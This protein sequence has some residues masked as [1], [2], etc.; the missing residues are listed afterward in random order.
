M[1]HDSTMPDPP[2]APPGRGAST[3]TPNRFEAQRIELEPDALVD[4]DGEPL[5]L[6]TQLFRDDTRSILTWNDSPDIPFRVGCSPYRG[7]EHGCAYCYA[8]PSHEYLGFSAGLEFESKIV[9]KERAADLLR[10]ELAKKSWEPQ[11]V[12]MSGITDVYQPVERRLGL[13]RRCLEVFAEFRNPVAI[14]TKNHLVTRDADLLG[15]LARFR[16][17]S[18]A[19]SLTTLDGDLAKRLEPRASTPTRRLAA[20]R[21]LTA[22]GVPVSVLTAP[23]IPGLN[24][25]EIPA[26]LAAGAEAGAV[27]AH[28]TLVR[29]PLAVTPIF[30]EWLER[31]ATGHK[32]KVLGRLRELREGEIY[33]GGFGA[34]MTGTGPAAERLRQLFEVS[35]R[36]A[37]FPAGDAKLEIGS[38]GLSAAHFRVPTAQMT[39]W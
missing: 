4:D 15:A 18:V 29:L 20:I 16:A 21:E 3:N 19:I 26:L 8:R 32:E 33:R 22:A 28:Y 34:R 11:T 13:T 36:R 39:L 7:C 17:A 14:I 27:S 23:I 31:H 10:E 24:D 6:R 2:P 9:V 12:A 38:R 35:A 37:G 1:A 30:T 25:H 5:P